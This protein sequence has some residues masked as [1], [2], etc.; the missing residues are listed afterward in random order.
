MRIRKDNKELMEDEILLISDVSDAL[1][2]PPESETP[3]IYHDSEQ[4]HE[5]GLHK[6]PGR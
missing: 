5:A 1:A 3:E 6:G 4:S 2:H